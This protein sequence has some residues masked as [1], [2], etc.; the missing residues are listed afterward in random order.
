MT[1]EAKNL[2]PRW[3]VLEA[4]GHEIAILAKMAHEDSSVFQLID[5]SVYIADA[6][7]RA[8]VVVG[9]LKKGKFT[10]DGGN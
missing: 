8:D 5:A 9:Q 6:V 10:A 4:I 1:D 3:K 7:N 2:S